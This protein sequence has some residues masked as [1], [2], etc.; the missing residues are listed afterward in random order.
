MVNI[1]NID[2]SL[3]SRCNHFQWC[4]YANEV[5]AITDAHVL[6]YGNGWQ[7]QH[8]QWRRTCNF[9][10]SIG[11]AVANLWRRKERKTEKNEKDGGQQ[12]HALM[13][14]IKIAQ[15]QHVYLLTNSLNLV[16]TRIYLVHVN[17]LETQRNHSFIVIDWLLTMSNV[18][19]TEMKCG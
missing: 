7:L 3:L 9:A 5:K 18:C 8:Q 12:F 6:V 11:C 1:T 14:E 19:Y 16:A 15:I 13:K 2:I 10:R 4:V 17:K